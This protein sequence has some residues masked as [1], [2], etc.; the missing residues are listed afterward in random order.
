MQLDTDTQVIRSYYY[1]D[2]DIGTPAQTMSLVLDTGSADLWLPTSSCG[3]STCS[4]LTKYDTSA[5]S[6]YQSSE[7]T[8]EITYGSGAVSGVMAGDT[9]ALAGYTG[10]YSAALEGRLECVDE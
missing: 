5:S 7:Q 6:T 10:E 9:V 3:S 1:A 8:F 4:S 2:V